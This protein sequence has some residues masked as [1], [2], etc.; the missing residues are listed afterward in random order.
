MTIISCTNNYNS[1]P[2]KLD[3][4]GSDFIWMESPWGPNFIGVNSPWGSNFI[5]A[6]IIIIGGDS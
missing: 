5:W 4:W 6:K 3:P 2:N 1:H